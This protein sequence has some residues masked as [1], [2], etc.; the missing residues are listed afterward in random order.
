MT[1]DYTCQVDAF[2]KTAG[3]GRGQLD[4]PDADHRRCACR[5]SEMPLNTPGRPGAC[6][7]ATD[8]GKMYYQMSLRYYVPGEGIKARSEGLAITRSYYQMTDGGATGRQPT[9]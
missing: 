7:A 8:K 6:R 2:G 3:P 4:Q 1:A 5:S 9:R